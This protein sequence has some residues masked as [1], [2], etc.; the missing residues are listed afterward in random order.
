M[1]FEPTHIF[2]GYLPNLITIINI[3]HLCSN[4]K[5]IYRQT[6]LRISVA[7]FSGGSSASSAKITHM[8]NKFRY[9]PAIFGF[10]L[11][12]E[13]YYKGMFFPGVIK[14]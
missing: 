6:V 3:F 14:F 7:R 10:L 9:L 1:E 12:T 5:L 2:S 8:K 11:V 13:C 4:Y